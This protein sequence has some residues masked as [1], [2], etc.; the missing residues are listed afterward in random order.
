MHPRKEIFVTGRNYKC[1]LIIDSPCDLPLELVQQDGVDIINFTY[2]LD[3]KSYPDDFFRS[4]TPKEFYDAMRN[5]AMP[6]TS[7]VP[8]A[9]IEAA[10]I[11]AVKSGVPT[12]YLSMSSGISSNYSSAASICE[13]VL[14]DYPDAELYVVDTKQACSPEGV[15]VLEA[16]RQRE[17]GLTAKEMVAWAEEITNFINIQ[18]MVDDLS[19]LQRGGRIPAG[20]AVAGTALN[21]KPL[22][23]IALDGTLGIVGAARGRKKAIKQMAGYYEKNR[24]PNDSNIVVIGNADCR[25]DAEKLGKEIQKIDPSVSVIIHNI[26]MT[27][28]SHVGPGMLAVGFMGN[29]RRKNLSLADRIAR[30]VKGE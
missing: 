25:E 29:D 3:G 2:I 22:L 11:K 20:V 23:N 1:N 18:F 6:S 27:I 10:F 7:Q 26:G 15:L 14:K 8:P 13:R 19:T 12:V 17:R 5:G 16:I 21:V 24:Q 28:G 9:E 30:K 4:T